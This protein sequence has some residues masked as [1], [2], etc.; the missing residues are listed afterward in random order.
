MFGN[1]RCVG[2]I[3]PKIEWL[4]VNQTAFKQ[5]DFHDTPFRRPSVMRPCCIGGADFS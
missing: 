5:A 1:D 3:L 4:G 2:I